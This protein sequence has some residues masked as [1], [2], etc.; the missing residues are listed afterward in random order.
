MEPNTRVVCGL[1]STV[2]ALE[3]LA[4][5]KLRAWAFKYVTELYER[6]RLTAIVN[7]TIGECTQRLGFLNVLW[8]W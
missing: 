3:A 6:E 1:G 5:D 7:P 8:H 4:A 2:T